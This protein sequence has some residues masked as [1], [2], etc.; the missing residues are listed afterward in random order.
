MPTGV[1]A[2]ASGWRWLPRAVLMVTVA[3][4]AGWVS[5]APQAVFAGVRPE[6]GISAGGGQ[7]CV[8]QAGKAYCWG[9]G[10]YGQLGGGS[11]TS[12]SVPVPVDASGLLAGKTLTQISA[13]GNHTCA[14]DSAGHAYCWGDGAYGELGDGT[15][16][17]SDVPVAVDASGVLAGKTLTQISGGTYDTCAL[18]SAGHAYCWGRNNAG[19]LGDGTFTDSD[20]PVAVDASGVLAGRTLIQISAGGYHTCAL[21]TAGHGYC[22]GN[23]SNGE[24]GD[25][26][27][28]SSDV[29]VA[30]DASGVLAG[31]T[32]TQ[33]SGGFSHTCALD[34]AGHVY[35]WGQNY[36]GGLG[37]ATFT[38]SDVP[39]AVDTSG[40]LAGK[41]LTQVT[42]GYLAT[43][44]LDSASRAYCW[45]N[46]N[47]GELGDHTTTSSDVPVAVYASGVLAGKTLTRVSAGYFYAC[48]TGRYGAA[49]CW[50]TNQ[51][52]E[53]GHGTITDWATRPMTVVSLVP[54]PPGNV[55]GRAGSHSAAVSWTAPA[56]LGTG[57]LTGYTATATPGGRSCSTQRATRCTITGLR[58]GTTYTIT[59][60]TRTTTV[61][62][63]PSKPIT[64]TP[65]RA[66]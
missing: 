23:G 18:D 28:I 62:S 59:V 38:D 31:K 37:D 35:C 13:G 46:N 50:G 15:A 17:S 10:V 36:L 49:Y 45:G 66:T 41:T 30:V 32:L 3:A 44:A 34:S 14:L 9:Y 56:S 65:H 6:S 64:V 5:G 29:P 11:L 12:S 61:N 22:W 27:A 43:C 19:G 25:G 2:R 42:T 54:Q 53:L 58:N 47:T 20:V 55:T 51:D 21:D 48:A 57:T 7:T 39:V 16:A 1:A 60:I 52:G 24:L 26:T 40:V 4:G 33:I 8:L 63:A